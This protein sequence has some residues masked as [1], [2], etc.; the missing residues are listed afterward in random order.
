MSENKLLCSSH[1][2]HDPETVSAGQFPRGVR[3]RLVSIMGG[4]LVMLAMLGMG[5]PAQA[6]LITLEFTAD[7]FPPTRLSNIAAPYDTVSG[8]ITYEAADVGS[9]I[10]SLTSVSLAIGSHSYTVDELG[11]ITNPNDV[12]TSSIIGGLAGTGPGGVTNRTND[13]SMQFDR[14]PQSGVGYNFVYATADF[15]GIWTSTHFTN[16]SLTEASMQV[17]EPG[18]LGLMLLGL[19]MAVPLV[20]RRVS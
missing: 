4:L 19:L 16:F 11:F 1:F 3:R 8:V 13:F 9:P 15:Y 14:V 6:A 18:T 20:C 5:S 17:P 12:A 2:T 10:E 7:Q